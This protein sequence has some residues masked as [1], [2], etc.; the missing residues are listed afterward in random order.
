MAKERNSEN[1]YNGINE[2]KPVAAKRKRE[3]AG[4]MNGRHNVIN[5][6]AS[7]NNASANERRRRKSARR[8]QRRGNVDIG[9]R[10]LAWRRTS[11]RHQAL[12]LRNSMSAALC[13][14]GTSIRRHRTL[15]RSRAHCA[16][17]IFTCVT[18]ALLAAAR[19]ARQ[20]Q[21]PRARKRRVVTDIGGTWACCGGCTYIVLMARGVTHHRC[22]ALCIA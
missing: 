3:T 7:A 12:R 10:A 4:E 6:A 14:R 17:A 9:L 21:R 5:V 18:S 19:R 8:R 20:R 2:N 16:A 13:F 1:Q 15:Q 11:T 22:T